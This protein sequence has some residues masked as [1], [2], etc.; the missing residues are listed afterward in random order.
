MKSRSHGGTG[1][2]PRDKDGAAPAPWWAGK[3]PI[4]QFVGLFV[5]FLALFYAITFIPFFNKRL[6][7]KFQVLNAVVSASILNVFGEGARA[8]ETSIT[9]AR[10][11]V[12]IAHGCDAIDPI[13]LFTAAVLAFPSPLLRKIPGLLTGTVVLMAINL[14]RIVSLY[15]AR[16]HVPKW[17]ETLHVDV[18]QPA[19]VLLSLVFWILWALW[20][21]KPR[22]VSADAAT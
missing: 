13:L 10:N 22:P 21:T 8:V 1:G 15:Y 9:S 20:A 2:A 16:I 6:L 19:F 18:W 7:P 12:D 11:S 14:I 5:F 4:F 17:F 3:R